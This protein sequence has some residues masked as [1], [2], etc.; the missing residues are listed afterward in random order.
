MAPAAL[1]RLTA[2]A[3]PMAGL[4]LLVLV[5]LHLMS[6]AVQNAEQLSQLFIPLLVAS[7][8]GLV[9]MV[10]VIGV[11]LVQMVLRY[12]RQVAGSRLTLRMVALFVAISLVPV[13]VVFYYSEQFLRQGIDSWFDV[14]IGQAMEDALALSR[15]S[16]DLHK[17]ERLKTTRRIMEELSGASNTGL[18]LSLGDM[19]EKFDVGELSLMEESGQF[20]A[21]VNRDPSILVPSLPDDSILQQVRAGED[22]VGLTLNSE[23]DL[24]EVRV[25][26]GDGLRQ[27]ILQAVY[28][29]STNLTSLTQTVQG[30]YSR[31]RE[32]IYLRN[33]LKNTFTIALGLVL[34]FSLLGA[35]WAAFFSARRLVAPITDIA[36]GTRAVADG[37]YGMQLPLPRSHDE[38]GFLVESFNAMTRR[39]AQARDD[40]ASSRRELEAQHA[41]LET[42]LGSLTS[43][44]LVLGGAGVVRTAN[45]AADEILRLGRVLAPGEALAALSGELPLLQQFIEAVA[46]AVNERRGDWREQVTLFGGEG[47]QVLLCRGTPL[48]QSGPGAGD[49]LL[50]FDD[51]TRLITAQRDAAWGEVARR[52]AHEIKNPL[53]PIQLSAERLRH[54]YLARMEGRDADVL[55]RATHTIVQQ[56]EAMKE[57]VNA[58]SEY[59]RP[60]MMNPQPLALDSLVTEVLELY[61]GAGGRLDLQLGAQGAAVEADPLRLRQ[62]LHNLVKNALEAVEGVADGKVSVNTSR[63][64]LSRCDFVE[65]CV[66]DNGAGFDEEVLPVL[67]EPYVTTKSKGTGLGLAVVKKIVEEHGGSIWAENGPERGAC[68]ILRLPVLKR[69]AGDGPLCRPVPGPELRSEMP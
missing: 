2:G 60:P 23:E 30:G 4:L 13:A 1:K 37:E 67:F 51:I 38:L 53:T 42:V 66:R 69:G 65:L 19:R 33:S 6:N 5:S 25:V 49:Y 54:K 8:L 7:V 68:V 22:F 41:H 27:M 35:I 14:E 44:V 20:I 9:A 34:L 16:L 45:R 43:G 29:T 59:A 11:N 10:I 57:M 56:V 64:L 18:T 36:E 48:P 63:R 47:R 17:R 3:L 40:A 52:L 31:Y 26:V 39:I 28:N 58:F 46:P 61:H 24:M 12:R 55:D 50:V 62:V 21:M 15:A 32:L